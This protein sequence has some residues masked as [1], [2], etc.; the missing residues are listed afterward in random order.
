MIN[1]ALT[2][3]SLQYLL[4]AV[5]VIL[6]SYLV[7]RGLLI[8][9]G[10]RATPMLIGLSIV[11]AFYILSRVLG[12][13]TLRWLLS[14]FF[15]SLILLIVVIFQEEI[16]RGLTKVGLHQLF[17][18]S[19]GKFYNKTIEDLTLVATRL[20]DKKIGAL[21]VIQKEVGLDEFVE[22]AVLLDAILN[23]KLLYSIFVK[24]SALH[25]GAVLIEGDRIRAA[26]CVLPLS[27]DPDIDPNLGTRH[28]AAIGL[29]E[30]SDAVIIVVSEE[31]GRISLVRE[32]R[33]SSNLDGSML[34]DSLNT[35]L[36]KKTEIKEV[37]EEKVG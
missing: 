31:T 10:T 18:R 17:R 37:I 23:R 12:L 9:R 34:R 3:D 2:V 35:Y 20:S 16:R 11:V 13:V 29:S 7:Y 8:I 33:I 32:G 21:I 15:S 30:R 27:F 22:E 26:G 14:H 4:I 24:D 19:N 1:S 5:D 28:R 6:V 36:S 25:D